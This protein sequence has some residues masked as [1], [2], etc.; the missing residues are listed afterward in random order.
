[1]QTYSVRRWLAMATGIAVIGAETLINI[2][3]VRDPAQVWFEQPLVI[4]VALSGV[5]QAVAMS[6]LVGSLRARRWTLATLTLAGL[7]AAIAFSFTTSYERTASAR[8]A[9]RISVSKDN[10]PQLALASK[11]K[12]AR[13]RKDA[14][15]EK[16]GS[17]CRLR[18]K[19]LGEAEAAY[20]AA[21][22][23]KS[24]SLLGRFDGVPELALPLMLTLLGFAFIAF[25]ESES[26]QTSFPAE[27]DEPLPGREQFAWPETVQPDV[28]ERERLVDEFQQA[29][30]AK[31]GR[32]PS[33][34]Q[35]HQATGIPR[36]TAHR[37]QRRL[38][39]A[40]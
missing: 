22:L 15:C 29:Y 28:T 30:R 11:V 33:A 27:T 6:V 23:Q 12:T 13:E 8:E 2:G 36:A 39:R 26:Q 25:A 16:R 17:E 40:V 20:A 38:R 10:G 35:V 9:K 1:M 4:A 24:D 21:P 5:A 14:E 32:L 7:V 34:G 37:Y 19:E 18:E 3:H 31:H